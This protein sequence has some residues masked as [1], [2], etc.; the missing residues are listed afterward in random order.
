[1]NVKKYELTIMRCFYWSCKCSEDDM[2]RLLDTPKFRAT[3]PPEYNGTGR[4]REDQVKHWFEQ[5]LLNGFI[6]S[7]PLDHDRE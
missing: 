7:E 2:N 5:C 1:M 3:L 6:L 4:Y